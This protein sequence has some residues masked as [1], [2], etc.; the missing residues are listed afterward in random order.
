MANGHR[1]TWSLSSSKGRR[2]SLTVAASSSRRTPRSSPIS[3]AR[4]GEIPHESLSRDSIRAPTFRKPLLPSPSRT[5][6][7]WSTGL[8]SC[9]ARDRD[10]ASAS[11]VSRLDSTCHVFPG[12]SGNALVRVQDSGNPGN[13]ISRDAV[14]PKG[15][16]N[17]GSVLVGVACS[18]ATRYRH[19]SDRCDYSSRVP[20]KRTY[21]RPPLPSPS[22]PPADPLS[23]PSVLAPDG[24]RPTLAPT[25]ASRTI[26]RTAPAP[27]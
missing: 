24:R 7:S 14:P 13:T 9:E 6:R 27:S 21:L 5:L 26:V 23:P 22:R 12:S 19:G 15:E 16:R 2:G 10:R 4:R 25:T 11:L 18:S 8:R 20:V 1:D 3:R 17:P